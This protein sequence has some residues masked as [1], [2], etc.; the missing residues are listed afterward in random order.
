MRDR[1]DAG[2]ALDGKREP[3]DTATLEHLVE[4]LALA[5]T[6]LLMVLGGLAKGRLEWRRR[7]PFWR[8]WLR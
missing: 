3:M 7:P 2:E 5:G 1:S 6:M 4:S 8:R